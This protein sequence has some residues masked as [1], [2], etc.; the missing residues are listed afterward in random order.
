MLQR[1][2]RNLHSPLMPSATLGSALT[3]DFRQDSRLL[4]HD[5]TLSIPYRGGA[6]SASAIKVSRSL[7]F[8]RILFR[9]WIA[10]E[11]MGM[12]SVHPGPLLL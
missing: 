10:E 3:S 12:R 2:L 7:T 6:K 5:D 4:S 8:E 9:F 1:M 11:L